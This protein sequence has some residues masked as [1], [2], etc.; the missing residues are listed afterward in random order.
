MSGMIELFD[1]LDREPLLSKLNIISIY[2]QSFVDEFEFSL[3]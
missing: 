3:D 2:C 1:S